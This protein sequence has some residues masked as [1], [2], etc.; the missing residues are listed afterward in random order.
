VSKKL[1]VLP[2]PPFFEGRAVEKIFQP[3]IFRKWAKRFLRNFQRLRG[4]VG[5][6]YGLDRRL[7]VVQISR[8]TGSKYAKNST[9]DCGWVTL[10][11]CLNFHSIEISN[12]FAGF[13][14]RD[15][16]QHH[17]YICETLRGHIK[18]WGSVKKC[19]KF[20]FSE[21]DLRGRGWPHKVFLLRK[22]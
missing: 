4:F 15:I 18:N 9:S 22:N 12:I 3:L 11:G 21:G 13:V 16:C 8:A 17:T 1:G 20:S 2:P 14:S 10:G 5:L 6:V 7:V 19:K